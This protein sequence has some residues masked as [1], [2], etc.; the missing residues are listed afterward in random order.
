MRWPFTNWLRGAAG[1]DDPAPD[2]RASFTPGAAEPGGPGRAAEARP[3]GW[4][5]VPPI[6]RVVGTTP[7]TAPSAE[8]ALGLAGR[9]ETEITH[10]ALAHD[11]TADG[12]VGLVGGVAVARIPRA[13][14]DPGAPPGMDLPAPAVVVRSRP[15]SRH[16]ASAAVAHGPTRG[17]G[18]SATDAP[19]LDA[20]DAGLVALPA[21][22][23]PGGEIAGLTR[24]TL[25]VVEPSTTSGAIAA[26]HVA[27]ATAPAT[28]RAL[29]LPV[30]P[31]EPVTQ[32]GG[33]L[34]P[35][36]RDVPTDVDGFG[37][38]RG[39]A[40]VDLVGPPA[41]AAGSEEVHEAGARRTLG[42]SRRLGLG[43]PLVGPPPS[44]SAHV[45]PP[46]RPIARRARLAGETPSTASPAGL[47]DR[48]AAA[49][50]APAAAAAP[51][52]LPRLV[53]ARLPVTASATDPRQPDPIT[54]PQEL[55]AHGPASSTSGGPGAGGADADSGAR[56]PLV[57]AAGIGTT[58]PAW[59]DTAPDDTAVGATESGAGALLFARAS[60]GTPAPGAPG[61]A[62]APTPVPGATASG[63]GVSQGASG[64]ADR[65]DAE[66]G[67]TAGRGPTVPASIDGR[68][69]SARAALGS[70]SLVTRRPGLPGPPEPLGTLG[71]V[72]IA[73]PAVVSARRAGT[74]S[75]ADGGTA[76]AGRIARAGE[77][78]AAAPPAAAPPVAIQRETRQLAAR[79]AP[80]S[81]SGVGSRPAPPL[82]LAHAAAVPQ[83]PAPSGSAVPGGQV[84]WAAGSGFAM[85]THAPA[86]IVQ[87]AVTIDE[88]S[89]A[90]SGG[91]APGAGAGP[92]GQAGVGAG[93]DYEELADHV[94]EAIRAR[95]ASD[96]LLD[97]E[98]AGMLVDA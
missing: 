2:E 4:L 90:P 55:P 20:P 1:R 65:V 54:S 25:Q 97:R 79:T 91:A 68:S 35:A 83:E 67:E 81:A 49:P 73:G 98:R 38:L 22:A 87:R 48:T 19:T 53:V 28:A 7:M 34:A 21:A 78:P 40:P 10:G 29:A 8:F 57:G 18:R 51:A 86:P 47:T 43:A 24:R 80:A 61:A 56:H 50:P 30:A 92:D 41:P 45:H 77:P 33:G 44:A 94:Y 93:T 13:P 16:A 76:E 23:E 66:R 5:D 64:D 60:A 74:T 11:V 82:P 12:P 15:P 63:T 88:M 95:L 26:T 17:D 32:T 69:A 52:P 58:R 27:D 14:G 59:E 70:A 96:L 72:G 89:V 71:L 75:G 42:E 37:S 84:S 31:V 46:G 3:A 39:T 6:E 85:S 36:S 62:A 9:R